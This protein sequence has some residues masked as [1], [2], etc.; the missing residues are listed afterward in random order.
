MAI[1]RKSLCS[2][3]H[4]ETLGAGG[5]S[6]SY[7]IEAG[8]NRRPDGWPGS[9][10]NSPLFYFLISNFLAV[11]VVTM[12]LPVDS[13]PPIVSRIQK[14]LVLEGG[15]AKLT[16]RHL[17][18]TDP[19]TRDSHVTCMID[20]QPTVGFLENVMPSPGSEISN[21][22][23]RVTSFTIDDIRAGYISYV[24]DLYEGSEPTMDWVAFSCSD[25]NNTSPRHLLN[26]GILPQNDEM[27]QI[28]TRDFVVDEGDEMIIDVTVLNA[29]DEDEPL[30]ELVFVV[31]TPPR[32]GMI[33]DRRQGATTPVP[34]FPL[35]Q[36]KKS[37]SI[38]YQHDGS[39]ST[40]DSFT[41]S[42]SDGKYNTT[43]TIPVFIVPVDDEEPTLS[44]NMGMRI[45]AVGESKTI[46]P[47][48][49]QAHDVD[50]PDVNITFI[51]RS[52][53]RAGKLMRISSNG[54]VQILGQKARFTQKDIN[55]RRIVYSQD[56]DIPSERDQIKF[57]LTDGINTR[58]NQDFYVEISPGDRIY[59]TVINRGVRLAQNDRMII[60]TNFLSAS[61]TGSPN[62][63]LRYL[64]I[65][66]PQNGR[67][68]HLDFPG[69]RLETFT[70]LD[71]AGNKIVYIHTSADEGT[72]DSFDFEVSDGTNRV[73]RTFLVT[74]INK[75]NKKPVLIY[76]KVVVN[77]GENVLITPFEVRAED[78][79]TPPGN[80]VYTVTRVPL[81]GWILNGAVPSRVFTQEDINLNRI[82][83]AHDGTDVGKD[84]FQIAVS[85]GTHND[86]YVFP[87][88]NNPV[89]EGREIPIVILPVDNRIPQ[90]VLNRGATN[91]DELPGNRLGFV[92]RSSAL[93][94][95]DLDSNNSQLLYTV[96]Y[97]PTNGILAVAGR[98]HGNKSVTNFTQADIDS[99]NITYVLRN[100]SNSTNDAFDFD[101]SDPAGNT[102]RYQRFSL[103][104]AWVSFDRQ[105]YE[106]NE[107]EGVLRLSVIRR[108]FL[109]EV[110]FARLSVTGLTATNG[111][112]FSLVGPTHVQFSPGQSRAEWKLHVKDDGKYEGY[113]TVKVQLT[114]PQM[115]VIR[116]PGTADV[117][118]T[119][120][121]D[122]E[123]QTWVN[124]KV[125][126][127]KKLKR[128]QTELDSRPRVM[129]HFKFSVHLRYFRRSDSAAGAKNKAAGA[130]NSE[131]RKGGK[132]G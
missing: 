54:S 28:F 88:T 52:P 96:T 77:E 112:D 2:S 93:R 105:K 33:T 35:T 55:E 120:P 40:R 43:R 27:P 114:S 118:I 74:L 67:L 23:K 71:L 16:S 36:I 70:Q 125:R 124:E 20:V 116:D 5:N 86:F 99:G 8:E 80:L 82:S 17:T 41:L 94:V 89:R 106:I 115:C 58:L 3:W 31:V 84:S 122:G 59:P 34:R 95:E 42:V 4:Y 113:E 38:V 129:A 60:S 22:G 61:D 47:R 123:Y 127:T 81:H 44:V 130:E 64:L 56:V 15:T 9:C 72:A 78:Q 131:Q 18:I 132:K 100:G 13:Q 30:D 92:I 108:G 101:V 87:D 103:T 73:V 126:V 97:P 117:I 24:Q 91:L 21:A 98:Y 109:G 7:A 76:S 75:D 19:D 37:T 1:H 128:V 48:N 69:I 14:L 110:S 26:I 102:L 66:Q 53:P 46:T 63:K 51:V 90:L 10:A 6:A 107:T 32:H 11:E 85:D 79:D 49:L 29:V 12:I 57:D 25:G 50:S 119:D 121:E 68:E 104:W 65:K 83:Y 62:E 39:E 45:A 111:D